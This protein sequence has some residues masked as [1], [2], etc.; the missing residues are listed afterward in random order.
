M[1]AS[2]SLKWLIQ[3]NLFTDVACSIIVKGYGKWHG[4]C[5]WCCC[6]LQL[7]EAPDV[8]GYTSG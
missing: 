4:S 3:L 7:S 8:Y 1:A 2:Y 6:S 5:R